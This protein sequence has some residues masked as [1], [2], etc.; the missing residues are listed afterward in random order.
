M[1]QSRSQCVFLLAKRKLKFY[2]FTIPDLE[3]FLKDFVGVGK[4]NKWI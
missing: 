4:T 1:K 3:L 2:G